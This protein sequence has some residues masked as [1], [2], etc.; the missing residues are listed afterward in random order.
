MAAE[1]TDWER[2]FK[3]KDRVG[4]DLKPA[5]KCH[6]AGNEGGPGTIPKPAGTRMMPSGTTFKRRERVLVIGERPD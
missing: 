5:P 2:A 4:A 3:G 6:V 1:K